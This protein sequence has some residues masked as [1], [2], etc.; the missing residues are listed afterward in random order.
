MQIEDRRRFELLPFKKNSL[1][2]CAYLRSGKRV[3][4]YSDYNSDIY[5]AWHLQQI[6]GK[7]LSC[8]GTSDI[9]I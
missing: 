3:P 2:E 6:R 9:L 7:E 5:N 4:F 1:G 8:V